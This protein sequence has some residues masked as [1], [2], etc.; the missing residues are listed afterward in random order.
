M[1]D[2]K[3][4]MKAALPLLGKLAPA[5][6]AAI[7]GPIPAIAG[8]AITALATALGDEQM[9][10]EQVALRVAGATPA[11]LLAINQANQTFEV[12]MARIGVDV[13][14]LE[15]QDRQGA[16]ELA[17]VNMM[18]QIALSIVFIIGYFF[19]LSHVSEML[20]LDAE[21]VNQTILALASSL[22]GVFTRELTT[23]MQFW[24]G[25][26]SGS[27]EKTNLLGQGK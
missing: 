16:R 22:L 11:D 4:T 7:G 5:L 12:S 15:V 14:A 6:L 21:R 8:A 17:K 20:T 9:T 24:F 13:F 27:K 10:P 25:T 19:A 23:I 1:S 18:P 3:K 26:S 2:V